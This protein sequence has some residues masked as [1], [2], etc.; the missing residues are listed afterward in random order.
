MR[1]ALANEGKQKAISI[2]VWYSV[3]Y[4]IKWFVMHGCNQKN[5]TK[6]KIKFHRYQS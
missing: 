2:V 4:R 1:G 6:I 5:S 3:L